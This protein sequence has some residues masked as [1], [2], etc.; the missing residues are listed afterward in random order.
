MNIG[1]N[2]YCFFTLLKLQNLNL[3]LS[4]KFD[5]KALCSIPINYLNHHSSSL[6]YLFDF[7]FFVW[8]IPLI[9][10]FFYF[11]ARLYPYHTFILLCKFW[12][13]PHLNNSFTQKPSSYHSRIPNF[14][15][16]F[17]VQKNPFFIAFLLHLTYNSA[18]GFHKVN[19]PFWDLRHFSRSML[20]KNFQASNQKLDMQCP[21]GLTQ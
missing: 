1:L 8:L 6:Y 18:K 10:E 16:Y 15:T 5:L 20:H 2:F 13:F 19:R 11:L 9:D 17:K 14:S 3:S 12:V 21:R 4:F 7:Y